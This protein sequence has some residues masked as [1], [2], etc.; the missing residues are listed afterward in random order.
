MESS[1]QKK[2]AG[3]TLPHRFHYRSL[4]C[5]LLSVDRFPQLS[6]WCEFCYLSGS[7]LDCGARLRV[8]PVPCLPLGD[9][10]SAETN[11]G[12]PIPFP[13]GSSDAVHGCINRSIRL[14]LADFTCAC[15]LV[16]EIGFIHFFS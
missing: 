16:N 13:E 14:R 10:E 5:L 3:L 7:D 11:Q 1:E 15:N 12:Y 6:T 9:R 8:A 4:P 2:T